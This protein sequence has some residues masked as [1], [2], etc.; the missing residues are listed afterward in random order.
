MAYIFILL[1][2]ILAS[3]IVVRVGAL[4][5]SPPPAAPS[6]TPAT[7]EES[8]YSYRRASTGSSRAALTA[9]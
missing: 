3:Y 7:S 2:T 6:A 5:A 4:E 9:G 8:S 1:A